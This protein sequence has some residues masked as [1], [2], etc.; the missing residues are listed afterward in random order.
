MGTTS[1]TSPRRSPRSPP[2]PASAPPSPDALEVPRQ[3]L[4]GVDVAP[5][6]GLD[7]QGLHE[8]VHVEVAER[9]GR[10]LGDGRHQP[11]QFLVV[12]G[13]VGH[14]QV[15]LAAVEGDHVAAASSGR[16]RACFRRW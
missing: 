4:Q 15:L 1:G 11:A 12:P 6:G 14:Q 9:G 7:R 16:R 13:A 5:R 3:V 10:V 2:A 8:E